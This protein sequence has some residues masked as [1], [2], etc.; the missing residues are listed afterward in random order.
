MNNTAKLPD[1]YLVRA[2]WVSENKRTGFGDGAWDFE[3]TFPSRT[4]ADAYFDEQVRRDGKTDDRGDRWVH[5]TV[6]MWQA[7]DHDE[8]TREVRTFRSRPSE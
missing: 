8:F 5:A 7:D 3:R 2:G 6:E 1:V 4:E